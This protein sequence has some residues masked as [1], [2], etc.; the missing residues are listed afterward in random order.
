MHVYH[1]V[2]SKLMHFLGVMVH[3]YNPRIHKDKTGKSWVQVQPGLHCEILWGKT[4]NS[5]C[6][7]IMYVSHNDAKFKYFVKYSSNC[8]LKS[9]LL[10]MSLCVHVCIWMSIHVC[11]YMETRDW[12]ACHSLDVHFVCVCTCM[13]VI[14]VCR[15]MHSCMH[16]HRNTHRQYYTVLFV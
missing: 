11:R 14:H 5:P 12:P 9:Y 13:H 6:L 3:T 4:F 15:C 8:A 2:H 1:N 7:T 16:T 10:C